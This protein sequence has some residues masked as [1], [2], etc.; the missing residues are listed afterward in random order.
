MALV[1]RK[2]FKFS[3][4]PA[5][6]RMMVWEATFERRI[7]F[8]QW[9]TGREKPNLL[10]FPRTPIALHVCSTSR[11]LALKHYKPSFHSIPDRSPF[12]I[13]FNSTQD[14]VHF[15]DPNQLFFVT[16]QT[17]R[18]IRYLIIENITRG[19]SPRTGQRCLISMPD[20]FVFEGLE[21]VTF[22]LGAD[23]TDHANKKTVRRHIFQHM[24]HRRVLNLK[25]SVVRVVELRKFDRNFYHDLY[26]LG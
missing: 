22:V 15:T 23:C 3:S 12:Y 24:Q 25:A 1:D 21:D 16:A 19:P 17:I 2:A 13:Y 7:F 6:L 18:L 9:D 14:V 20:M 10:V 4:L 26:I 11:A 8:F 5:E